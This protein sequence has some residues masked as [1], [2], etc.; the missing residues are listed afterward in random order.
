MA[1]VCP[2]ALPTWFSSASFQWAARSL[3]PSSR[4]RLD[5]KRIEVMQQRYAN[6]LPQPHPNP[7]NDPASPL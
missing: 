2:K 6:A 4:R 3:P 5:L 1:Q 7:L